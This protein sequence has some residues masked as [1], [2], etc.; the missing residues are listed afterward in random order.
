MLRNWKVWGR[1]FVFCFLEI[2]FVWQNF[3]FDTFAAGDSYNDLTMIDAAD[4]R[5]L[6]C[7]PERLISERPELPVARDH[8]ELR[9]IIEGIL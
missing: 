4:N 8:G 5:A 6:Y 1:F 9:Q 2:A 3:K 7:P